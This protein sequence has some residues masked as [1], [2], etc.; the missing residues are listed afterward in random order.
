M[1]HVSINHFIKRK[2]ARNV[3]VHNKELLRVSS[4]DLITEMV[5]TTGCAQSLIFVK[6]TKNKARIL[7]T[8]SS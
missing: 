4:Q 3:N 2:G 7:V 1:F 5:N 6:V 8:G